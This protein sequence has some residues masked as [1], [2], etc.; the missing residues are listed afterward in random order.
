MNDRLKRKWR[1]PRIRKHPKKKHL[2]RVL[3]R[4]NKVDL[5]TD[6]KTTSRRSRTSKVVKRKRQKRTSGVGE[7]GFELAR[8]GDHQTGSWARQCKKR[9]N[10]K[11]KRKRSQNAQGGALQSIPKRP[12]Q[13]E[14]GW[15]LGQGTLKKGKKDCDG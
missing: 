7:G 8:G 12:C 2:F 1:G 3:A 9:K 14:K 4:R 11:K 10:S 15:V 13:E 5:I 6:P